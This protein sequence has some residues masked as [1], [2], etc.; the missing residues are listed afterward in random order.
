MGWEITHCAVSGWQTAFLENEFSKGVL[1]DAKVCIAGAGDSVGT[2]EKHGEGYVISG[3][4]HY[5]TGSNDATAFIANCVVTE[6]GA[7]VKHEGHDHILSFLLLKD[8]VTVA[9]SWNATGL[10][11][12]SSNNFEVKGLEVKADRAF[13]VKDGEAKIDAPLYK[14]P[15]VQLQEALYAACISGMA[16]H[17]LDLCEGIL[18]QTKGKNGKSIGSDRTIAENFEKYTEKL[19]DARTKLYYAADISWQGCINFQKIKPAILYKLSAAAY[20]LSTKAAECVDALYPYCG[21]S[22]IDKS[23]EINRVWRDLHTAGQHSLL[24]FGSLPE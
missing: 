21:L 23:A 8:E 20:E 1:A 16:Y 24:V 6:G 9:N 2:A 13:Q 17:F 12:T 11:A 19:E 15:F 10:N 14:F 4:W 5:A 18:N 22:A 7:H 3:K